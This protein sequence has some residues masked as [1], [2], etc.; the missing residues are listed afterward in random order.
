MEEIWRDI[1]GYENVYQASSLGKVRNRKGL[2]MKTFKKYKT[3]EYRILVLCKDGTKKTHSLHSLIAK[4]FPEIC[5][6]Y[7]KGAEIDHIDGNPFNN[8]ASNLKWVSHYENVQ[9][10]NTRPKLFGHQQRKKP[11]DQLTLEGEYI[12]TWPTIKAAA[13]FYG[14]RPSNISDALAGRT[15]YAH[16]YKWRYAV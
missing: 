8:T 4:T 11:I 6:E 7:F 3:K 1:P 2:V 12:R 13:D 10:P 15:S 14:F 16:N 5:G 9:N